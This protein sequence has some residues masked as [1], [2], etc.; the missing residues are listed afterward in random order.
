M[1]VFDKTKHHQK[2]QMYLQSIFSSYCCVWP[3]PTSP[4]KEPSYGV[5]SE[6]LVGLH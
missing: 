6:Y 4:L 1:H 2:M 3:T 5:L